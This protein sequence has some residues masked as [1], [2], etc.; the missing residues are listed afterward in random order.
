M[1]SNTPNLGLCK[2]DP[3]IDKDKTFNI[4]T[5]LNDNWDKIDA[6][7]IAKLLEAK[8]YTDEKIASLIN[9]APGA[10]DTLNELAIALGNDPNFATTI[11]NR[12][13]TIE[14]NDATHW[15]DY[16][17]QPGYGVTTGS[18]NTYAVTL[19]PVPSTYVDGMCIAVKIN[20]TNT[21]AS[22]INVNGLGVKNII[23][24]KGA[25][26]TAGKLK[27]ASIYTM[28]L[29]GSNFILQGEGASGNATASD[30]LSGKT[31]STDA[32]DIVGSMPN[33]SAE[34][35]HLLALNGT[36]GAF[37]SALGDPNVNAYLSPPAGYYN[38]GTWIKY[39]TPDLISANILSGKS[40]LGVVG[41]LIQG[42][43]FATGSQT[44]IGGYSYYGKSPGS[45]GTIYA[46]QI[47][48]SG[49]SFDPSIIIVYKPGQTFVTVYM[50]D[51]DFNTGYNTIM[52]SG[53]AWT[54]VDIIPNAGTF[55][56]PSYYGSNN[57]I[58][59]IAIE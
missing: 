54:L 3:T 45:Q 27:A 41:S 40:I 55:A 35:E 58:N 9:A 37:S 34:N 28:R 49:L 53:S 21:G 20:V 43:K 19:N 36:A 5:M 8:G 14:Q 48:I 18:A 32:G 13:T 33:R 30:L 51:V 6:A 2:A 46:N 57:I 22:T 29:N 11:L 47:T 17:R 23:D 7:F 56:V 31:A 15:A 12:L 44:L 50:R 16:V 42:K 10:L 1:A 25:A 26:M 59:W 39:P 52:T 4:K 24:S 38:G